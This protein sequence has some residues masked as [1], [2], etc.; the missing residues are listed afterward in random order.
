ML[1]SFIIFGYLG[2][3]CKKYDLVLDQLPISGPGLLFITF[4]ACL[5]T[6]AWP[7]LWVFMFFLTMI[8]IGIDTQFS[9]VETV[10]YMVE[11]L[12]TKFR[13]REFNPQVMRALICVVIFVISL[14]VCM[15]GGLEVIELLDTFGYAL[16]AAISNLL[17]IVVWIKLTEYEIG[18][19]RLLRLTNEQAPPTDMWCLKYSSFWICAT[20]LF[21]CVYM[22][23]RD[24]VY[25]GNFTIGYS[26]VGALVLFSIMLPTIAYYILNFGT[27][28]SNY[29]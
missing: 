1:A 26:L 3:Y 4:P 25:G 24:G 5:S 15:Q 19:D 6:M 8:F 17:Q 29:R 21:I 10:G 14:P 11:H 28:Y 13:G 23:L 7:S 27:K 2:Y 22:T 9:L 20:L 18:V 12:A 16:P